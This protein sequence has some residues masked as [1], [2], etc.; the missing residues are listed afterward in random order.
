MDEPRTTY[1]SVYSDEDDVHDTKSTISGWMLRWIL[2]VLSC[3]GMLASY[4]VYDIPAALERE[5]TQHFNLSHVGYNVFYSVYSFP[6]ILLPLLGGTLIDHIG[7]DKCLVV[8][9]GLVVFGQFLFTLGITHSSY[10]LAVIGR[11]VFGLGGESLTVAENTFLAMWFRGHEMA[12]AMGLNLSVARLGSVIND[13]LSPRFYEKGGLALALWA[14][15]F[16]TVIGFCCIIAVV[17]LDRKS[18]QSHD[19]A[20]AHEDAD[21]VSLKD[22]VHFPLSYWLLT[23]SCV[24]VYATVLPFNNISGDFLREKYNIALEKADSYLSIPYTISAVLSPFLGLLV[25]R[26]G[27]RAVFIAVASLLLSLAHGLFS[28]T[29]LEPAIPLAII[30]IAYCIYAASIWPSIALVV[31]SCHLGTAYGLTTS[32][33]N[34]GLAL[35]PL[36]V[37]WVRQEFGFK[38]VELFFSGVA[39]VGFLVGI[40]QNYIDYQGGSPLNLPMPVEQDDADVVEP[41]LPQ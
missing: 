18:N 28:F 40:Y 5:L 11:C 14:G 9:L 29:S 22:I 24:V 20:P 26:F 39:F 12:M 6:N 37:G 23:I 3:V 19:A 27:F 30:G 8:F 4:Y 1:G 33:Q 32:V 25:D 10:T 35:V 31:D 34:L 21:A 17:Y 38:S 2:L 13:W 41:L 7:C 15:T 16:L 36:F